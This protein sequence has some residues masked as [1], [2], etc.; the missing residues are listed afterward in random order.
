MYLELAI[1]VATVFMGVVLWIG[2]NRVSDHD[3]ICR[4]RMYKQL[5]HCY[6]YKKNIVLPCLY[7]VSYALCVP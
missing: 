1:N 3:I 2:I 7:W 6:M 5:F 4:R